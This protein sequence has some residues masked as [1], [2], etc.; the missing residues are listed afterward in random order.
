MWACCVPCAKAAIIH[1]AL[2]FSV[3]VRGVVVCDRRGALLSGGNNDG[4]EGSINDD[5]DGSGG[6]GGGGGNNSATTDDDKGQPAVEKVNRPRKKTVAA[7]KPNGKADRKLK[8]AQNDPGLATEQ[9]GEKEGRYARRVA[10]GK[11]KLS[12]V[13]GCLWCC[14]G[15]VAAGLHTDS[16]AQ[17]VVCV[18]V[19]VQPVPTHS[20]AATKWSARR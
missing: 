19:C 11:A 12:C 8:K 3:V 14:V 6:A 9:T 5:E 10:P 2:S 7:R 15:R 16:T 1:V 17:M 18:V 20:A 4:G 13:T